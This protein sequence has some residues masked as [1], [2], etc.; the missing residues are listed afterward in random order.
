MSNPQEPKP[1]VE[2]TEAQLDE[3]RQQAVKKAIN[4]K[5][6]WKQR[7]V[8]VICK[9]C[10]HEHALYIGTNQLLVGLNDDGTPKLVKI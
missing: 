2:Y 1:S 5:H 9:T 6:T 3:I 7:G 4:S 10:E 8:Y